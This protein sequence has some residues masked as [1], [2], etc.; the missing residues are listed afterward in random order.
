MS[1]PNDNTRESETVGG[2]CVACYPVLTL[3]RFLQLE[4]VVSLVDRL[5]LTGVETY[6]IVESDSVFSGF[7]VHF[8]AVSATTLSIF[9]I[10]WMLAQQN[11]NDVATKAI[12]DSGGV[13]SAA[14][15]S[16]LN[17]GWMRAGVDLGQVSL[18]HH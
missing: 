12:L 7:D 16:I 8:D 10:S 4:P 2:T 5:H 15:P 18:A 17:E 1:P 13:V 6:S 11:G 3:V 14:L 9:P